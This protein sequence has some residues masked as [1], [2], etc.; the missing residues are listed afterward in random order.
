WP[1][2]EA[3]ARTSTSRAS[4]RRSP[5]RW[6]PA[7]RLRRSPTRKAISPSRSCATRRATSSGS[8]R[9]PDSAPRAEP[10]T[11][12][13]LL[14]LGGRELFL[15][16]RDRVDVD[17]AS[18]VGLAPDSGHR[19]LDEARPRARQLSRVARLGSLHVRPPTAAVN[20]RGVH[21]QRAAWALPF[22]VLA[23]A[24]APS[25]AGD[26]R[27]DTSWLQARLDSGGGTIFLPSLPNGECYAT[28]GLWVTHD[29]TT[30]TS[31]GAC[32]TAL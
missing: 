32:I 8:G 21:R 14:A 15:Q 12:V 7:E 18:A 27:D 13:S 22:V 1:A 24:L 11:A 2:R 9:K 23:L 4:T 25:A 16:A 30:I 26:G 17:A 31:D 6:Q 29:D 19:A 10:A 28:R 20:V 3:S 5:P